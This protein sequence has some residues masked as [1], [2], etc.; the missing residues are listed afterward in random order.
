[1]ADGNPGG[2]ISRV[3]Y[4][5]PRPGR[6]PSILD[7][8]YPPP[9]AT[10]PGPRRA[11]PGPALPGLP[12]RGL[13]PGEVYPAS[14]S[15]D[16][17]WALTPPFHP[18]RAR[19]MDAAR[20]YVSV[21]L[22]CGSP[23]LGV[24]QHPALWSS[25]FPQA[26]L[27]ARGHPARLGSWYRNNIGAGAAPHA[28]L[29]PRACRLPLLLPRPN[30]VRGGL[31]QGGMAPIPPPT[32][33]SIALYTDDIKVPDC[34]ARNHLRSHGPGPV[35]RPNL[36]ALKELAIRKEQHHRV[37]R[38]G[39]G[40]AQRRAMQSPLLDERAR[41]AARALERAGPKPASRPSR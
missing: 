9:P 21:A 27:P 7:G 1:M 26:G 3:L 33:S 13:A 19:L 10:Y 31:P 15:P 30:G 25:D 12:L 22:S 37:S 34:N 16:R 2:P 5:G 40:A 18:Y 23:R 14:R 35:L 24:T 32:P 28:V 41:Y 29:A 8:D 6:R 17:W 36:T 38:C 20:R 39:L 11:T 4:P